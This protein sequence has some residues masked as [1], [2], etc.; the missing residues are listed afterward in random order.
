MAE[1][2]APV[3]QEFDVKGPLFCIPG[4]TFAHMFLLARYIRSPSA[5]CTVEPLA[6]VE[7]RRILPEIGAP[8]WL[9]F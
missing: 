3:L 1:Y 7:L 2:V 9:S 5:V 8:D 4:M 6:A